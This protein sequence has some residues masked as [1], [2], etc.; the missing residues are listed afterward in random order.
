[1]DIGNSRVTNTKLF[2]PTNYIHLSIA[3]N[4]GLWYTVYLW[5]ICF[6]FFNSFSIKVR[7]KLFEST[8]IGIWS[9]G[10]T[11]QCSIC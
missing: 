3:K 1:M 11:I 10:T 9:F 5:L 4:I 8:F 2:T 7:D 6:V